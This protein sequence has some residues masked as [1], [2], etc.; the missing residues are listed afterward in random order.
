MRL[1]EGRLLLVWKQPCKYNAAYAWVNANLAER[2]VEFRIVPGCDSAGEAQTQPG[3]APEPSLI[4]GVAP[5]AQGEAVEGAPPDASSK[6]EVRGAQSASP[7]A[8]VLLADVDAPAAAQVVHSSQ[9]AAPHP[10]PKAAP[11]APAAAQVVQA[12]QGASPHPSL[13]VEPAA[14]AAPQ[15]VVLTGQG[16]APN[17]TLKAWLVQKACQGMLSY[18]TGQGDQ[19]VTPNEYP[20]GIKL[21]EGSFAVTYHSR[22]KSGQVVVVKKM[23]TRM[24]QNFLQEVDL[25]SKLSHPNVVEMLDVQ[26]GQEWTI[27]MEFGGRELW[28]MIHQFGERNPLPNWGCYAQQLLTGLAYL[29][30]LQICHTDI[31]PGNLVVSDADRLRIVD[32]GA[33]VLDVPGFPKG[34]AWE[35]DVIE[36]QGMMVGTIYYRAP[37]ILLGDAASG[38]PM[39]VWATGCTVFEMIMRAILV[40][41]KPSSPA[42]V[43]RVILAAFGAPQG[44]TLC[45]FACLPLWKAKLLTNLPPEEPVVRRLKRSVTTYQAHWVASML[46]MSP[47]AAYRPTAAAALASLERDVVAASPSH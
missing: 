47:A 27:V 9:G 28:K 13:K 46:A 33:A 20:L 41:R 18:Q 21:G 23:R 17:R 34:L 29:H 39:D 1:G 10:A 35:P 8:L 25:L 22:D 4:E 11:A 3:E 32:F 2:K 31:K 12:V 14:P 6:Q 36:M 45:Y 19:G 40:G 42:Q 26:V 24:V 38:R 30:S 16:A 7:S 37:E 44:E 15:A 5:E 43:L